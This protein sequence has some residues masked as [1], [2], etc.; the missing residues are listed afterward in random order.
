MQLRRRSD[1]GKARHVQAG[2]TAATAALLGG[3]AT[4]ADSPVDVESAVLFYSEPERVTAVEA[5][6][7]A[8]KTFRDERTL[9]LK[10]VFDA[11]TGASANGATPSSS[12]QTFTRPSG[13]GSY[14]AAAGETPLDDTFRDTRVAASLGYSLPLG[15]LNRVNLGLYGSTEHD[16]RSLGASAGISRDFNRRNTTLSASVSFSTDTVSPEGGVPVAFSSMG[17]ATGEHDDDRALAL[18]RGDDDGEHHGGGTESKR[19]YD[20]VLGLTQVLT[21]TTLARVNVAV[22]RSAG[23]TTDPYKLLSVVG[24]PGTADAGA[25]LDYLFERRPD[26]RTKRS[27]F[28][29]LRQRLGEDTADLSYRY[30]WDDWGITS[31]TW[32]LRYRRPLGS[33]HYLQP[34]VRWYRQSEASFFRRFLVDGSPLPDH[35]SADYRLGSLDALTLGLGVGHLL[36]GDQFLKL[37]VE[38]YRQ[39]AGRGP[40][41]GF[42]ALEGLDLYPDVGAFMAR[43]GYGRSF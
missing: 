34:H 23:Y 42:G 22:S 20:G 11:L 25:P 24:A 2:L 19:V 36:P 28:G 12:V 16:Y 3:S 7:E 18:A 14:S 15:R 9:R 33:R 10:L 5:V 26:V 39:Y 35:A 43:I 6:V 27:I 31:H 13:Q 37:T 40:P 21:R 32:E 17:A 4:A 38:Y 1:P 8:L 30:L 41:E 29:E